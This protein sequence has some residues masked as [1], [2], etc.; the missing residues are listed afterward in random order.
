MSDVILRDSLEMAN[1]SLEE[2]YRSGALFGICAAGTIIFGTQFFDEID[3][4]A[5]E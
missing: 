3:L 5:G 2:P 4:P 1:D